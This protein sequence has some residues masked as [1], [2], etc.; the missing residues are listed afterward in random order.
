MQAFTLTLL[1]AYFAVLVAIGVFAHRRGKKSAEDYFLANRG[2]GAVVLFFTLA[3][4]NFSA[5]TFLGFAGKAYTD[6]MGEYGV[7]A[8]GT[9]FMALMFYVI[10]RKVWQLGKSNGYVTPGELVGG[11]YH[12]RSLQ[13]LFTV[14]MSAFTIPYLAIQAIGAGYILQMVFPELG[15]K[16]GAIL[17]M[18]I[19][20]F[21]VVSGGMKASGWTDVLQGM[22][23]VAAM[24]VACAFIAHSLGGFE[25]ATHAA[26]EAQPSL[27]SRP[28]P[29]DYF[30]TQ[31]W[32]SF[33]ILWVFCDPMFPQMFT[34]F[35]TAKSQ[36][37]LKTAMVAYPVLISFFFLLP[38]LIGVWAHGTG[39]D[40]ANP[41]NVLLLMVKNYTPFPVFSFVIVGALAALMS[42]ADSQLLSLSTMITCD[43][44]GKRVNYSRIVTVLLTLFAMAF[45]VFGYN[46][47]T[48]IMGTLVKTTFSG[49]VVLS[50]AVIATLY[51]RRATKW[52]C[53][54]SIMGGEATVFLYTYTT[55]PTWGFLPAIIALLVSA[56]LLLLFSVI[57]RMVVPAVHD[58]VP[59]QG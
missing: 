20:C 59:A 16:I 31:L 27:F 10:G 9:A 36:R 38:V 56:L 34:R 11:R 53:M 15:M 2:F 35:Y 48:G 21:Y 39:M 7:M 58:S 17:I 51:W 18:G 41:D 49:L 25:S 4:T 6:G 13:I 30:T 54:A 32:L 40:V 19:I 52:G 45:V 12:S 5:F 37:S 8:V 1:A 22:I 24:L 43:M 28:G 46:P 14:I 50:P 3:A 33:F 57:E 55:L 42:T 26:F 29:N 44:V 47:A 23:M